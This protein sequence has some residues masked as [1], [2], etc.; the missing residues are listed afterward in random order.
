LLAALGK[1]AGAQ[2]RAVSLASATGA[3]TVRRS[4]STAY[5]PATKGMT[6]APGDIVRT[7]P[8]A[9]AVI[10]FPDGS[11]IKLRANS[12]L[13]IPVI[14]AGGPA[15]VQLEQG[16]LYARIMRGRE[17]RFE[18]G[19]TAVAGVRGTEFDLQLAADQTATLTVVEGEVDFRNDQGA[20]LVATS[21]QSVARPGQAPTPPV[22]VDPSGIIAWEAT[23]EA[24][25][26]SIELPLT[27][28]G[29]PLD[30]LLLRRERLA[31]L[32]P[33][34]PTAVLALADV[35]HA[36]GRLPEAAASY[37]RAIT[38][39]GGQPQGEGRLL[40]Q[41]RRAQLDLRAGRLD[42]ATVAFQRLADAAPVSPEGPL[43][44]ALVQL[45]T[46]RVATALPLLERAAALAPRDPRPITFRGVVKLRQGD[47]AGA[48]A[49][50]RG[51]LALDSSFYPADAY[52]SFLLTLKGEVAAAVTT[53]REGVA[54]APYSGLAREALANALL[55]AG[56]LAAAEVEVNQA[57]AVNP[58][59]AAARLTQAK[60]LVATDRLPEGVAA[61]QQAVALDPK[62][63]IARTTL[64]TLLL[65]QNNPARAE[66]EFRQ[67]LTLAPTL[68]SAQ[69]GLSSV[70]TRRG[71]LEEAFAQQKAAL[72]LDAT[73]AAA[74]NNLGAIYLAQGKLSA[75]I[76]EF[77]QAVALQP[78]WGLPHANLA[79]AYLEE[80]RYA[81]AVAEG[82]AAVRLGEDSAVLRTTLARVYRGQQRFER[83]AAELRQA[84][85]LDPDYPLAQF[86]LSQ[87]FRA[88]DRDQD[89]LKAIL[90][91]LSVEPGA[92][93]ENRLYAR[94]EA[95][96]AGGSLDTREWEGK[97]D[98]RVLSGRGS[99]RVDVNGSQTDHDRANGDERRQFGLGLFGWDWNPSHQWLLYGSKL[100][101][102]QGQPGRE[103]A[104]EPEDANFRSEFDGWETHLLHRVATGRSSH[105]TLKVGTRT[106]DLVDRNPDAGTTAD[107]KPFQRLDNR[108]EQTLAEGRWDA[109]VTRRDR[110]TF[111][112][113]WRDQDSRLNGLL[114]ATAPGSTGAAEAT[115]LENSGT[116]R[117]FYSEWR[118][119]AGDR[120]DL[121]V[122]GYLDQS[123]SV[124]SL[125]LPK[126]VARYRPA[127]HDY[128]VFLAYPIFRT[129]ATELSPVEAW[130][131]PLGFDRLGFT[132]DG[133]AMSYELHY[134][135][136]M[137]RLSMLSLSAF[138]RSAR[139]LLL[140]VED[141]SLA[142]APTRPAVARAR[143]T[144]AQAALEHTLSSTLTARL[145][146][147]FQDT[148]DR[149][150]GREL[151]SFNPWEGGLRLS[152]VDRAGWRNFIRFRYEGRRF[153]DL[154][155]QR[156][157]P[158][159]FVVDLRLERQLSLRRALF[160]EITNLLDRRY[161]P[162]AGY[163]AA[164]RRIVGGAE[165]RF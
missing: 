104:G 112:F 79:Q 113:A 88:Q 15:R 164:G 106:S 37:D 155:N 45:A 59:S 154:A 158:G 70:Y 98:G 78:R 25:A 77:R 153:A 1:P 68:A 32:S 43:G 54:L 120:F 55:F 4:A 102:K 96:L 145:F 146:A 63:P 160:L 110:L 156:R 18:A 149:R 91:A 51:A 80:N 87:L 143:V 159:F 131:Q 34:D 31:S 74:H 75:A 20:V 42:E 139:G 136:P 107:V 116:Q 103:I 126:V 97:T 16:Q 46:G 138:T 147:G 65:A 162:F 44:L 95:M 100:H 11:S 109:D 121:K 151:P 8:N 140:E 23:V 24:L 92:M 134:Q 94:T 29:D 163:P 30:R 53:A 84:E 150:T 119:Q 21:Q 5:V 27:P 48:E 49:D 99:Y 89:A 118:H 83:A 10:L 36:L 114:S 142:P 17:A 133:W 90:H 19:R 128:L 93:V 115:H 141:A 130:A 157:L 64:G 125:A 12:A 14:R 13:I 76:A 22:V 9:G 152:Y 66:R 111:G 47:L 124:D 85:A 6:L 101:R 132:E 86:L 67:A 123:S 35:Q 28:P 129:D 161:E 69:T 71:Q 148:E 122:G 39:L 81:E 82:E 52:L 137:S 72:A 50:L 40:A 144:G 2:L 135:R 62:S 33:G 57:L 165:L 73:S 38:L 108:L 7:G 60:L 117:T 41:A 56:D 3:T 127:G 58:L 61:A 105:L 26:F